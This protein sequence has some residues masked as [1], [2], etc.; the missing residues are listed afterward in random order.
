MLG[1]KPVC[2]SVTQAIYLAEQ[3]RAG[4]RQVAADLGIEMYTLMESAGSA[5]FRQ[6]QQFWPEA[7]RILVCCGGETMAVT[8]T[9]WRLWHTR[10]VL[11]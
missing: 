5:V 7:T 11:T 3:V 4:E 10:P 6:L 8:D 2:S 1:S 9:L